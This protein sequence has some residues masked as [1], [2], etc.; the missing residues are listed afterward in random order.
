M[1]VEALHMV[2]TSCQQCLQMLK[3]FNLRDL[4]HMD[5]LSGSAGQVSV[6][7]LEKLCKR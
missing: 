6:H 5:E 7:E 1:I 3:V 2:I 4:K